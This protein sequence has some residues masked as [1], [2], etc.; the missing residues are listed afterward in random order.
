MAVSDWIGYAIPS[1]LLATV[2]GMFLKH[3]DKHTRMD[4]ALGRLTEMMQKYLGIEDDRHEKLDEKMDALSD[5][6]A[7]TH[8]M[9]VAILA[10]LRRNGG[11]RT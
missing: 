1:G 2:A 11:D 5:Q 10:I 3:R 6:N 4:M 8:G 7:E 9:A